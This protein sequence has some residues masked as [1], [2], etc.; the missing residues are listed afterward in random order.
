MP[1]TGIETKSLFFYTVSTIHLGLHIR[2]ISTLRAFGV[3][4]FWFFAEYFKTTSSF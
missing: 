1:G 2:I 3:F 4:F